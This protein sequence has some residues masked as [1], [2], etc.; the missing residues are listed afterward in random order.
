MALAP[1]VKDEEG[2]KMLKDGKFNVGQPKS[3]S[4]KRAEDAQKGKK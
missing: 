1:H 2:K 4:N 3:V